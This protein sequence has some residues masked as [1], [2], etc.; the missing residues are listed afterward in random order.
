[1]LPKLGRLPGYY[2]LI[3][4]LRARG[5]VDVKA[6]EG[7]RH[8]KEITGPG[9]VPGRRHIGD[10]QP[11]QGRDNDDGELDCTIHLSGR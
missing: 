4:L 8:L 9:D 11:P 7:R 3:V 10:E 6:L 2:F 1:M 5:N